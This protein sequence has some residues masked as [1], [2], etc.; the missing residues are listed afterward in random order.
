MNV[1]ILSEAFAPTLHTLTN[2]NKAILSPDILKKFSN[3]IIDNKD[4]VLYKLCYY[5]EF[6][7][8]HIE[9]YVCCI[10][11]TA[12][13]NTIIV[14]NH[15]INEL[16]LNLSDINYVSVDVF[17]P[18]QAT[19]VKFKLNNGNILSIDDIK[20]NLEIFISNNHKFLEM[21]QILEVAGS[22]LIVVELEPYIICMVNNTDMVVEFEYT[23]Q[24]GVHKQ[25][26]EIDTE[27]GTL[28]NDTTH[29]DIT[30]EGITPEIINSIPKDYEPIRLSKKELRNKRLE[31]Y[32][33]R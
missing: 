31:F 11:F 8:T 18:P 17:Y 7:N 32:K 23:E 21:D 20:T 29:S 27:H 16:F 22:K 4:G 24:N 19:K 2:T 10:E 3:E 12:P 28:N 5:N 1:R 6:L 30:P 15:I 13:N 14:S 26:S 9:K 25:V 33:N